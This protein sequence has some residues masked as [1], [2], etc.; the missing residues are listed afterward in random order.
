MPND[1]IKRGPGGPST[2]KPDNLWPR[3]GHAA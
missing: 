3:F 1:M 2:D